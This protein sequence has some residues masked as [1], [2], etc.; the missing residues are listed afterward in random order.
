MPIP[1][2]IHTNIISLDLYKQ[3]KK[4]GYKIIYKNGLTLIVKIT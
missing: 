3:L 2:I 4:D 1:T